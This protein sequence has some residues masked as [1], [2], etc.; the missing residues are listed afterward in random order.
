MVR[1]SSSPNYRRFAKFATIGN[2]HISIQHHRNAIATI[3]AKFGIARLEVFGS[4]ARAE[5]FVED[6]SDADFLVEFLPTV[7]PGLVEFFGAKAELEKLLGREVDLVQWNAIRN[8][9]VIAGIN[10]HR[11]LVYAAP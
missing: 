6:K 9:Y 1:R 5:D 4:A 3:C 8:P 10:R 7:Q 2:M 11:E